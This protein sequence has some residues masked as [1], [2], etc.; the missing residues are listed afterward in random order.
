MVF[1]SFSFVAL[2]AFCVAYGL[3]LTNSVYAN[4]VAPRAS[5]RK[6]TA[7]ATPPAGALV[8][9]TNPAS[10]QFSSVTAAINALPNDGSAQ[11]IFIEAGT[12]EG[13]IDITRVGKLT[14]YHT[15]AKSSSV[16]ITN[17]LSATEAGSD[18]ASGTLRIHTDDFSLYN[19]NVKNTFGEGSQA[20]A[21][22]AYGTNAG[23]YGS[24]F[25]SYQD[26]VLAESGVQ[27]YGFCYIEG[28]VDF[29][30]G[31]HAFAFFSGATI[32]SVGPGSITADGPASKTDGLF[33]I[34]ASVIRQSTAATEDLTGQ[35]FLGRPWTEFATVVYTSVTMSDIINSAGWSVWSSTEPNTEDVTFVEF[36]ST[37]AGA[38]GTRASF[39]TKA[40]STAGYTIADVLGSDYT[41]WVDL[42]YV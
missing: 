38:A 36:D 30:F 33:V 13:Q 12:Y 5:L 8:V 41:N 7:R 25:Y 42:S 24:G 39:S 3:L 32:A 23:F 34:D 10:G 15:V 35:V 1:R 2:L 20:L 18:D 28:A 37:G 22:S 14:T 6:R 4:P 40:T 9:S 11:T 19:V 26:T 31:Q 17:S 27:F 16:L 29:I 21:L